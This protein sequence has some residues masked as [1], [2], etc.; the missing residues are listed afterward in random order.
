MPSQSLTNVTLASVRFLDSIPR[1]FRGRETSAVRPRDGAATAQFHFLERPAMLLS[2]VSALEAHYGLKSDI[3]L[4]PKSA[5]NRH[6]RFK[7][8]RRDT[9]EKAARRQLLN[10][11]QVIMDQ[12]A[13]NAGFD[14]RR[15]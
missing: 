5:M 10:S 9:K 8:H 12:A 3:A 6:R 13:I 14:F 1:K 7:S 4:S 2:Q 11:N 15:S